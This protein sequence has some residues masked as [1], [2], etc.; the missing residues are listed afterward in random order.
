MKY[1]VAIRAGVNDEGIPEDFYMESRPI[2]GDF[3][4]PPVL[5]DEYANNPL[6]EVVSVPDYRARQEA[7]DA[8][9]RASR[10]FTSDQARKRLNHGFKQG[11]ASWRRTR[12]DVG[13]VYQGNPV[14]LT[15]DNLATIAT[16]SSVRAS[17]TY[18]V[19][20]FGGAVTCTN[21]NGIRDLEIAMGNGVADIETRHSDFATR[22]NAA[23]T[24]AE[25]E[26]IEAEMSV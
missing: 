12:R 5:P 3:D 10:K 21:A 19:V 9:F 18:P 23:Q 4:E 2:R 1:V 15:E 6:A 17:L 24:V 26:A 8:T 11:L 25:L 20:L 7:R 22:A 13:I 14:P 16:L